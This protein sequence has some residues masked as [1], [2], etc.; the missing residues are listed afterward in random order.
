[1][2]QDVEEDVLQ[3]QIKG[4]QNLVIAGLDEVGRGA[5]FGPVF[6]GVVI[7]DKKSALKLIE[8]GVKDSK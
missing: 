5:L 6:A 8:A 4:M 1:M 2:T 7:L 3:H